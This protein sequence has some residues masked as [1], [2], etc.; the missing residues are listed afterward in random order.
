MLYLTCTMLSRVDL[1]RYGIFRSKDL[2][3]LGLWYSVKCRSSCAIS[4]TGLKALY[5]VRALKGY[6]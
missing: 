1:A 2:D 3:N 4:K 6:G 5:F